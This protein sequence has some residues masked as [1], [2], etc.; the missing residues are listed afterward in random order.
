ML[1]AEGLSEVVGFIYR[2]GI[3]A[4][5]WPDAL[6]RVAKAMGGESA[7]LQQI[8]LRTLLPRTS[9][10]VGR[11]A[12]LARSIAQWAPRNCCKHSRRKSAFARL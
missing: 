4:A 7:L 2:A 11:D 9:L 10:S 8:D 1:T 12:D 6:R 5:L 3:D